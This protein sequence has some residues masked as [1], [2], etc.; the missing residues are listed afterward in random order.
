LA[1]AWSGN[2]DLLRE[3]E[4]LL[5]QHASSRGTL[6]NGSTSRLQHLPAMEV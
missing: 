1:D 4:S 3:V 6:E 5:A 2:G